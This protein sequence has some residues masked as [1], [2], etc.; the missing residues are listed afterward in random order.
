MQRSTSKPPGIAVGK[1]E[2]EGDDGSDGGPADL[3]VGPRTTTGGAI[4]I[5]RSCDRGDGGTRDDVGHLAD[6]AALELAALV[7]A[8]RRD[9]RAREQSRDEGLA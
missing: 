9:A 5:L 4:S 8:A 7:L 2:G 3:V 1:T 6:E